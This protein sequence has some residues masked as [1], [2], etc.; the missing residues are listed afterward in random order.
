MWH[1]GSLHNTNSPSPGGNTLLTDPQIMSAPYVSFLNPHLMR[2]SE[3]AGHLKW[4]A[5]ICS[6]MAMWAVDSPASRQTM[7]AT[8]SVNSSTSQP[9]TAI[10]I[11]LL[12]QS[13][14][15][16]RSV[17]P[18][19][20]RLV[21][22]AE[23][24][25]YSLDSPWLLHAHRHFI[26]MHLTPVTTFTE[27]TPLFSEFTTLFILTIFSYDSYSFLLTI[28]SYDSLTLPIRLLLRYL[29]LLWVLRYSSYSYDMTDSS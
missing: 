1:C 4:Q 17:G 26:Q 8:S 12:L 20:W 10:G 18:R 2:Y 6:P 25:R 13:H 28:L 23:A 3:L 15:H 22:H 24:D 5:S 29:R 16:N 14:H 9:T 7:S 21:P 19:T 11:L 27:T